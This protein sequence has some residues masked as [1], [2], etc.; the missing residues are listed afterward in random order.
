MAHDS[1]WKRFEGLKRRLGQH[2][3]YGRHI[4]LPLGIPNPSFS[5]VKRKGRAGRLT[6]NF[7]KTGCWLCLWCYTVSVASSLAQD[8]FFL[9]P[10]IQLALSRAHIPPS[11]H[12]IQ[13][14]EQ[15][16]EESVTLLSRDLSIFHLILPYFPSLLTLKVLTCLQI[17]RIPLICLIITVSSP[18]P[19][20]VLIKTV[21]FQFLGRA[22]NKRKEPTLCL[23]ASHA[24]W[25]S[26]CGSSV[27]PISTPACLSVFSSK[28]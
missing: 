1:S 19:H 16:L 3:L 8:P 9:W 20:S 18:S 2:L 17:S 10:Q 7:K 28:C 5:F 12:Q 21:F 4:S 22:G 13:R 14:V 11:P 6:W 15:I 24:T 25:L 27:I 26:R 23:S